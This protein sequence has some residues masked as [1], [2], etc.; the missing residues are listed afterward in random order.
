MLCSLTINFQCGTKPNNPYTA[1]IQ[2]KS[3]RNRTVQIFDT[4]SNTTTG[5]QLL[6]EPPPD[7]NR[8]WRGPPASGAEVRL[9]G[10]VRFGKMPLLVGD[11]ETERKCKSLLARGKGGF[12]YVKRLSLL[13]SA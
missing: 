7:W 10:G 11:I 13:E 3:H 5:T 6:R 12:A 8:R 4:I 1:K 9:A 2:L